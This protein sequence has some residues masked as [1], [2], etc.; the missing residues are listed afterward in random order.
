VGVGAGAGA[1][2]GAAEGSTADQDHTSLGLPS[3]IAGD[4]MANPLPFNLNVD[5][6]VVVNR[7]SEDEPVGE[8]HGVPF[9]LVDEAAVIGRL[10]FFPLYN[11]S[12]TPSLAYP[13][14]VHSS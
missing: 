1:H 5:E 3:L 4:W 14:D 6:D 11:F 10:V 9:S 13:G 12:S 7:P 2:A 8:Y